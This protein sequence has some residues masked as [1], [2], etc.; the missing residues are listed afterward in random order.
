M[1]KILEDILE[2]DQID[3]YHNLAKVQIDSEDLELPKKKDGYRNWYTRHILTEN[4]SSIIK[5]RLEKQGIIN[6]IFKFT[7][8]WINIVNENTNKN[9]SYHKD[10]SDRTIIVY[11]NDNFSGGEFEY[12]KEGEASTINPRKGLCL[13]MDN[14]LLHKVNPVISGTRHSLVIFIKKEKTLL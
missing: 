11:L 14:E 9:D 13:L 3:Y 7:N 5:S 6:N 12:L 10:N 8:A 4:E 2:N 1:L